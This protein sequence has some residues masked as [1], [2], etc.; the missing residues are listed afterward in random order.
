[1][2]FRRRLRTFLG[3]PEPVALSGP[4]HRRPFRSYGGGNIL[5]DEVVVGCFLTFPRGRLLVLIVLCEARVFIPVSLTVSLH[6]PE[7]SSFK[8]ARFSADFRRKNFSRGTP[9]CF[10][11]DFFHCFYL[12]NW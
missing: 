11:S 6:P 3:L 7:L 12:R 8:T 10:F 4:V 5:E 9:F 1:M 2:F